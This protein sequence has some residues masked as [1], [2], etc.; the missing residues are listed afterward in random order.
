M[1]ALCFNISHLATLTDL[2][3]NTPF[4][5]RRQINPTTAHLRRSHKYTGNHSQPQKTNSL[6]AYL[7]TEADSGY[8]ASNTREEREPNLNNSNGKRKTILK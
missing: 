4:V 8:P 6:V 1:I 2:F 5:V 3:S 7:L